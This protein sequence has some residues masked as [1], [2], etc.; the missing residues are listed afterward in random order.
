[1]L[2]ILLSMSSL[3]AMQD[4]EIGTQKN[5]DEFISVISISQP[6]S[7]SVAFLRMMR[8]RKDFFISHE[9]G[10]YAWRMANHPEEVD[11]DGY[12]QQLEHFDDVR[13]FINSLLLK[14]QNN[15]IKEESY[16]AEHYVENSDFIRSR[17]MYSVFLIRDPHAVLLSVYQKMKR[18]PKAVV[19]YEK[20][21]ELYN[22]IK[23]SS[24]N[25]P[26]IICFEDLM[27]HPKPIVKKFCEYINVPFIKE[28]LKWEDLSN[29]FEDNITWHDTPFARF[30][31][32]WHGNA[33]GSTR[34]IK[35]EKNYA[36]DDNKKPTFEEIQEQLRSGFIEFYDEMMPFY[37]LFLEEYRMQQIKNLKSHKNNSLQF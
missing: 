27:Q 19:N 16:A 15:F 9:P 14:N 25:E 6:C 18:V 2:A 12:E 4:A 8:A 11:K 28:S 34:F 22:N 17:H 20:M 33:L 30:D 13:E 7:G 24:K 29:N 36:V 26:Y 10:V 37:E 1:M 32:N 21:W 35:V 31:K 3:I 5:I 23:S